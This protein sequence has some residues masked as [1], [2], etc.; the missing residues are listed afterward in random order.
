MIFHSSFVLPLLMKEL[1]S[2]SFRCWSDDWFW[3]V[4]TSGM[5]SLAL[6]DDLVRGLSEKTVFER[7]DNPLMKEPVLVMQLAA[8][9]VFGNKIQCDQERRKSFLGS[10]GRVIDLVSA[11]DPNPFDMHLWG[12]MFES[13][14]GAICA[15]NL[16]QEENDITNK[17][18]KMK[19]PYLLDLTFKHK[20]M[21]WL[22][23][24]K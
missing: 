15:L 24:M 13:W 23:E 16:L 6:R 14:F 17:L 8:Q 11:M 20:N 10:F 12:E 18:R 7:E 1:G 5:S 21:S 19:L 3:S 9:E 22:I 4:L 2:A